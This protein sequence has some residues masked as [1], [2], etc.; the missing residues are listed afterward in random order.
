MSHARRLTKSWPCWNQRVFWHWRWNF[1][2]P[3]QNEV[4]TPMCCI[5]GNKIWINISSAQYSTL[6]STVLLQHALES[7]WLLRSGFPTGWKLFSTAFIQLH[8]SKLNIF[9]NIF[10]NMFTIR[11]GQAKCYTLNKTWNLE[12]KMA[13]NCSNYWWKITLKKIH[14]KPNLLPCIHGS[15]LKARTLLCAP[16]TQVETFWTG[17]VWRIHSTIAVEWG[18]PPERSVD[19]TSC[20]SLDKI[21]SLFIKNTTAF[22][23]LAVHGRRQVE[24]RRELFQLL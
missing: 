15:L 5:W 24:Y 10:R 7:S 18:N 1:T 12:K 9:F 8:Q 14:T 4:P 21:I 17:K 23:I 22:R 20:V 16:V 11:K 3:V 6:V 13:T 2:N 19:K